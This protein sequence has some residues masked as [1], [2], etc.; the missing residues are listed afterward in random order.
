MLLQNQFLNHFIMTLDTN[1]HL[2]K[3]SML[4][5]VGMAEKLKGDIMI[6]LTIKILGCH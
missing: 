5:Q 3:N 1:L 2:P 4:M 6:I